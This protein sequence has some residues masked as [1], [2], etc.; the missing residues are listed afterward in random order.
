MNTT[1][2]ETELCKIAFKYGTDKCP[3][4]KH[5]YTPFYYDMLKNKRG[6]IKK[7]VEFGIGYYKNIQNA[8]I[9]YDKGLDRHY[10]KGA[11]L[12]MWRDFFPIAQVVGVDIRPET[13]FE[14][15]RIKTFVCDERKEQ[16]MDQFLNQIG[17]DIDFV[18]D[19][20]SHRMDDQIFL[21][22]TLL[23]KLNDAVIYVIEDV[24]HTKHIRSVLGDNYNYLVPQIPKKW[25]ESMLL[26]IEKK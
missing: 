18:V 3:R 14:D 9:V 6:S 26:V 2:P 25:R 17:T 22:K 20:A 5:C 10:H 21:A 7:V 8:D 4:I 19:D 13:M 15:E 24:I 16:D 1:Y 23:P 12:K 11:S